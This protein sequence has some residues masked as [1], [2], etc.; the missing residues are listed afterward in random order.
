M[1]ERALSLR[2]G[3][4]ALG[5]TSSYASPHTRD[6]RAL[7]ARGTQRRRQV[8]SRAR[9]TSGTEATARKMTW[10]MALC[11]NLRTLL[12]ERSTWTR[13]AS[14]RTRCRGISH[15]IHAG[16]RLAGHGPAAAPG[17]DRRVLA[18]VADDQ[19]ERR[20]AR[21][22]AEAGHDLSGG[23]GTSGAERSRLS[24]VV[25]LESR[26]RAAARLP[27]RPRR[28]SPPPLE[29]SPGRTRAAPRGRP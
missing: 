20:E 28:P 8:A 22:L 11:V 24:T 7:T 3:S 9:S 10:L 23:D 19:G 2:H 21:L 4:T 18:L 15:K 16:R 17:D 29:P 25:S 1:W 13:A 26:E 27:P 6:R 14:R 5:P 12:Q